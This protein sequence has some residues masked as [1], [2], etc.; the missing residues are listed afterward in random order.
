M[1]IY[2]GSENRFMSKHFLNSSEIGS[3]FYHMSR[4]R[5]S[6]GMRT[7]VFS[8]SGFT[9]KIL[10]D[11]EDHGS[12]KSGPPAVEKKNVLIVYYR[13]PVPVL[14]IYIYL[15]QCFAADR[16]KPLLVTF[17]CYNNKTFTIMDIGETEI[18]K[19]RNTQTASIKCFNNCF[20]PG[21]FRFA[22]I[23]LPDHLVNLHNR[24]NLRKLQSDF[25]R[26]YKR[27]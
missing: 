6:E 15:L 3:G 7:D 11:S 9:C 27:S 1:C 2:L 21:A 25:W 16:D 5:V 26:F 22:Q 13:K 24:K 19:F 17:S 20:I 12:C 4:E 18:D 10:D 23:N 8:Y 14:F